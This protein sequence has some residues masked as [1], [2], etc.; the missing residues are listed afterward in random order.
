VAPA[1]SASADFAADKPAGRPCPHLGADFRCGIHGELR[2]QGFRGCAVYDC[3]GAGQKVAQVTFRGQDWRQAPGTARQM[4]DVFS[5]MRQLHELLWYLCEALTLPAARPVH[6]DLRQALR[7]T[8]RLT[9]AGAESLLEL[10]VPPIRRDGNELLA[11][12]SELVRGTIPGRKKDFRGADLIE[13]DLKNADLR[14]A[15]FRGA[16]LIGANFR[17]ADLRTAD[18]TGADLRDAELSDADLTGSIFL[19][20][21]Q[22]DAASGNAA[23]RLPR[24]LGR[25]AHWPGRSGPSAS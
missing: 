1:F 5:V 24:T 10:D 4:F 18:W 13:A 22:L 15:S 8:E 3:F 17:G 9:R 14:G 19:T 2:R 12:A 11:R 16:Y 23:T 25:P 6:D 20:Q 21:S 7:D